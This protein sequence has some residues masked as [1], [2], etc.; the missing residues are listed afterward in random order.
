MEASVYT[1]LGP[2]TKSFRHTDRAELFSLI[3]HQL[4]RRGSFRVVGT[5]EFNYLATG[6]D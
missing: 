1:S 6:V 4:Y 2:A 3:I 5:M